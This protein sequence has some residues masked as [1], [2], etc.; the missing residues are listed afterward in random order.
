MKTGNLTTE[1]CQT[2]RQAALAATRQSYESRN[3]C[4]ST[5]THTHTHT[6]RERERDSKLATTTWLKNPDVI[7]N[8]NGPELAFDGPNYHITPKSNIYAMLIKSLSH[9]V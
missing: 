2:L 1:H 3:W 6:Q 5:H 4:K 7:T 8:G 9:K